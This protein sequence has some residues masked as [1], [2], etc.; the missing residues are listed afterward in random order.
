VLCQTVVSGDCLAL[1]QAFRKINP[2]GKVVAIVS[3]LFLVIR[4][5]KVVHSLDGPHAVLDAIERLNDQGTR[6]SA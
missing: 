5:D 4:A 3:G 6:A 2:K 1:T